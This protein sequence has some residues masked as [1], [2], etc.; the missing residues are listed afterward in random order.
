MTRIN[1]DRVI[2]HVDMGRPI[3]PAAPAAPTPTESVRGGMHRTSRRA[4]PAAAE[5]PM[6]D[7]DEG[8][9]GP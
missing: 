9:T 4:T 8:H 3:T 7:D 6:H 5:E 2:N 1:D